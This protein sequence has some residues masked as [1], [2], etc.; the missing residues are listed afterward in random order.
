[1]PCL[2]FL[3]AFGLALKLD[4]ATKRQ[5]NCCA[6]TLRKSVEVPICVIWL[7]GYASTKTLCPANQHSNFLFPKG[8]EFFCVALFLCFLCTVGK[9]IAEN[10]LS[11]FLFV[12]LK[13]D[14]RVLSGVDLFP[15]PLNLIIQRNSL[16][17]I[18]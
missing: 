6:V 9:C 17:K 3:S 12:C 14:N 1:M 16:F 10:K 8:P 2:C 15:D 5:K 11:V 13:T 7:A 4:Y 18:R